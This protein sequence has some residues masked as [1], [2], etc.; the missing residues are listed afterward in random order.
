MEE[1]ETYNKKELE[2]SPSQ[3]YVF[4]ML[5]DHHVKDVAVIYQ[6]LR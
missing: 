5:L 6:F 3:G 1:K 4:R 2:C